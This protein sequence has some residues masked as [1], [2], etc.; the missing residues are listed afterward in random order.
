MK[1]KVDVKAPRKLFC[2]TQT[3]ARISGQLNGIKSDRQIHLNCYSNARP[4]SLHLLS[5][6]QLAN[7]GERSDL[8][9]LT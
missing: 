5:K 1:I 3:L 7:K 8:G 4:H 2:C 9:Q 6:H